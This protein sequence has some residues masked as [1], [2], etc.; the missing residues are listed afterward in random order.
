MPT[1]LAAC[2]ARRIVYRPQVCGSVQP[3]DFAVQQVAT[4]DPAPGRVQLQ[5]LF[6]SVDPYMVRL[7][8]GQG[9][10]FGREEAETPMRGRVVA[11]VLASPLPQWRAGDLVMGESEW[12]EMGDV[13]A[14]ALLRIDEEAGIP[15]STW[16]GAAGHSGMTAWAGMVDIAQ[17]RS[18]ETVVVSAASGAVGSIAGQLA[19]LRGCR[20][21][22]IAGGAAKT[23]HVVDDL[24][25]DACVDYKAQ[26]FAEQLA[27]A[28]PDGVDIH[29]ENVGGA[30]F[31]AVLPHLN[32]Y[33]RISLCGLVSQYGAPSQPM[34]L[35]HF[36]QI[37]S[38]T[39]RLQAF[40][41]YDYVLRRD[42]I[43]AELVPLIRRG[44][45]RYRE[46]IA[47]GLEAAPAALAA[48]MAGNNLG[49]QLVRVQH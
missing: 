15:L 6:L 36:D 11:R 38:R 27:V 21:V 12:A 16:L 40:R 4:A 14:G 39:V 5:P 24:G 17:P 45:L 31:D 41:I 44:E 8:T 25:F 19:R 34:T 49:K 22:G 10:Y 18:G 9:S 46:S 48:M 30:V 1:V 35:R 43:L 28:V 42:E 13:D 7:L 3:Q 29:F 37:L 47:D 26:D 32:R 23:R 2:S 20:V 33:A